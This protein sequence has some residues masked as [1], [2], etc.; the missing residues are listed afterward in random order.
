MKAARLYGQNNLKVEDYKIPE[1]SKNE[2]LV[3]VK[4]CAICGT[5]IRMLK[6]GIIGGDNT[7]PLVLGHELSGVIDKCG[8]DVLGYKEG[9]R[10]VVAPNMGCGLCDLCVSGNTH[11]CDKYQALG[12]TI[13]GG[14]AQYVRIPASA[15]MQG[16]VVEIED[17]LSYEEGALNEPLSC[18]YNGFTQYKVWPGDKV[19]IMGAGPIGIMHAKLAKLA[20]ASCVIV[21]DVSN[22][23]LNICKEIESTI[24]A[25]NNDGL[26][27]NVM[28]LTRGRGVDVCVTANPAP[29]S[30]IM[31]IELMAI[32][33]RINFFGGLPK[34]K[35]TVPINTNIIHYK[36]LTITGSTRASLSQYR[37]TLRFMTEGLI[38][39]SNLVTGRFILEE[40]HI[41]FDK[42]SRGIGLKNFIVFGE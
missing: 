40:A 34:S 31:S 11:L 2:I 14:M 28:E 38:D 41:A 27:S 39:L 12:V 1:I 25:M 3:K 23:R 29:E 32:G 26:K 36:Q 5:D 15:V 13:D 33:G 9:M 17:A 35:E 18:V 7:Y 21:S 10:V 16:N 22:D 6:N 37:K 20:G 4:A 19:L 8:S 42:A 24:L 30:Q